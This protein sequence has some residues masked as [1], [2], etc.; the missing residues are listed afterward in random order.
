MPFRQSEKYEATIIHITGKFLGSI[1]R[2]AFE[3]AVH[4]L[5]DAGKT[6]LVL[7]LSKT[8]MIDST[9]IGLLVASKTTMCNAGGDVCLAGLE[10]RVKNVF[11]L[12]RLLGSVF[13]D[14]PDVDEALAHFSLA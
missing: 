8:D 11:L 1:E 6:R 5:K 10:D 9:G 4:A 7:D 2:S 14:Y 3:D 13:D 12:T